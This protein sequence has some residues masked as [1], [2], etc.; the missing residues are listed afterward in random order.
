D[1]IGLSGIAPGDLEAGRDL[2]GQIERDG[3]VGQRRHVELDRI[4]E[5]ER[6]RR[7]RRRLG[8][9]K[10]ELARRAR[11]DCRALVPDP[12]IGGTDRELAAAIGVRHP[13]AH[14]ITPD[15]D[16]WMHPHGV[17]VETHPGFTRRW[18]G[19][20]GADPMPVGIHRLSPY[21]AIR[22]CLMTIRRTPP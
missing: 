2:A 8:A 14:S 21:V 19:G 17:I 20:P 9:A 15:T 10:G 13:H 1:V 12:E 5:H 18:R 16:A 7:H 6:A 3:Q 22:V 11:Y 4:A